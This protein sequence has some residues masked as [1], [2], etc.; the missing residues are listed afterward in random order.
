MP[1]K[2]GLVNCG[3]GSLFV[4]GTPSASMQ[5]IEEKVPASIALQV[6]GQ[7]LVKPVTNVSKATLLYYVLRPADSLHNLT[8]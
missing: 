6:S 7:C 8:V 3:Q 4:R 5:K 1:N 2:A